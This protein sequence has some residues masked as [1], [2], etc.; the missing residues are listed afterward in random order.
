[1][2]GQNSAFPG[3]SVDICKINETLSNKN[4][5]LVCPRLHQLKCIDQTREYL[6]ADFVFRKKFLLVLKESER[7]STNT[8]QDVSI[9][10]TKKM[11][12]LSMQALPSRHFSH[13][14]YFWSRKLS[15]GTKNITLFLRCAFALFS[16][17]PRSV[18][19][20][21]LS[22]LAILFQN[23]IKKQ[24]HNCVR[25][26][27]NPTSDRSEIRKSA[28]RLNLQKE[29]PVRK[30]HSWH[31]VTTQSSRLTDLDRAGWS[32]KMAAI[33]FWRPSCMT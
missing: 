1:M 3:L 30:G 29:G 23:I 14:R 7:T 2:G 32:V 17:H 16:R 21:S 12:L 15:S 24:T 28:R 33:E 10:L 5:D 25:H 4:Y 11:K 27:K 26:G 9:S 19:N 18:L 13:A 22:Y 31:E 8:S 20:W 6:V